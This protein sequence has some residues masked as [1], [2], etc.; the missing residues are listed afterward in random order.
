M[1][2][3]RN[4][5]F[6]PTGFGEHILTDQKPQLD[7]DAGKADALAAGLGARRDVVKTRLIAALHAA[8]VVGDGQSAWD[9]IGA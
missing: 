8:T 1:P 4:M 6:A 7:A 3:T 9:G 2:G 5:S